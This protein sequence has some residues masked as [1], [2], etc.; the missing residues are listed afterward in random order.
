MT[1]TQKCPYSGNNLDT[2]ENIFIWSRFVSEECRDNVVAF[3]RDDLGLNMNEINTKSNEFE[4]CLAEDASNALESVLL[5][6]GW[7]EQSD[8]DDIEVTQ[9]DIDSLSPKAKAVFERLQKLKNN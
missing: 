8:D 2:E 5:E 1:N 9:K 3:L 6:N 4:M 7:V